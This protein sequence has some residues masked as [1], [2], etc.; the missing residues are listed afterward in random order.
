M[1]RGDVGDLPDDCAPRVALLDPHLNE[2]IVD[3][4][5][6]LALHHDL[7]GDDRRVA[8]DPRLQVL[9][10]ERAQKRRVRLDPLE[11]LRPFLAALALFITAIDYSASRYL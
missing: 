7:A 11:P 9:V 10:V 2:P 5:V 1:R 4:C 3:L 8:V 6:A